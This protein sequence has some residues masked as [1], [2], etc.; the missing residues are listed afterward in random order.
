VPGLMSVC[1]IRGSEGLAGRQGNLGAFTGSFGM[2]LRSAV[3]RPAFTKADDREAVARSHVS[4]ECVRADAS[5]CYL[6]D[7]VLLF[8][9]T[10]GRSG[11][12][13]HEGRRCARQTAAPPRR[14]GVWLLLAA[15]TN[16][17]Q[18]PARAFAAL[19]VHRP[20]EI[21]DVGV[22]DDA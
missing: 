22:Q 14:P 1:R 6:G 12:G 18:T 2:R 9:V 15:L 3:L 4:P 13:A 5:I 8:R 20:L 19:G 16:P 7:R 11:D 21:A 17:G 10:G